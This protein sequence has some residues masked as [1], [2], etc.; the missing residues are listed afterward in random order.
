MIPKL[1]KET[2][3]NN[4]RHSLLFPIAGLCLLASVAEA[5]KLSLAELAALE[6]KLEQAAGTL[7][8]SSSVDTRKKAISDLSTIDDPRAIVP[9]AMALR[10]DPDASVRLLA[11]QSLVK[12]KTPEVNGLLILA[13]TADPDQTVLAEAKKALLEFPHRM[14]VAKLPINAQPFVPPK[15]KITGATIKENLALPSGDA[16]LWAIG[17]LLNF[18]SSRR[19]DLITRHLKVDPSARVRIKCAN[20]LVEIQKVKALP[21]LVSSVGDGDPTVRFAIA[22]LLS[23]FQDNGAL[24]VLQKL[25][26]S[27]PDSVVKSEAKDLL[28]PST[29]VGRQLLRER[30]ARLS[31]ANPS[32]RIA[33][34]EELAQFTNWRA[35]V[36]MSCSLI[37]DKNL[38]VRSAAAK[39]LQD[40]HDSSVLTALRIAAEIEPDPKQKSVVRTMLKDLRK[41]VDQLVDQLKGEDS[42]RRILAARAL[43]QAV[44]KPGLKPLVDAIKD[45]DPRVRRAVAVALRDFGTKES[46]QALRMVGADPDPKIR[47]IVDRYF[48]ELDRIHGWHRFYKNTD[49]LVMKTTDKDPAM[50]ANAAI[51]LGVAGAERAVGNLIALLQSDENEEVRLAAAWALVLMA[52]DESEAALKKA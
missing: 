15:G 3:S 38:L 49:R 9:L 28:E 7:A 31:S 30:I 29:P 27:D 46:Q 20:L 18:Q 12:F 24:M 40:M 35:M 34:L 23:G 47:K 44:Y 14:N 33:A 21:T 37:N 42:N 41:K 17:E 36:P 50:R 51:A 43:G 48:K 1:Q 13:S 2:F 10:E 22:Q 8:K 45:K 16:R 6:W 32:I 25:A 26:A 52:S 4:C 11:I 5:K 19:I 39:S